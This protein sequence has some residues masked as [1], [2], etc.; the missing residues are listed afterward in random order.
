MKIILSKLEALANAAA[1]ELLTQAVGRIRC[2]RALGTRCQSWIFFCAIIQSIH[3]STS[4]CPDE[5]LG[6]YPGQSRGG[7]EVTKI[8]DTAFLV[9]D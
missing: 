5:T 2:V 6:K 3:L 4:C 1:Q 8:I 9:I 7:A